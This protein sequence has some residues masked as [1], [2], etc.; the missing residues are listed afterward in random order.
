MSKCSFCA[1]S[2][3]FLGHV[4][5]SAGVNVDPKKVAVIAKW[6]LPKSPTEVRSSL[7]MGSYFK[8]FIQGYSKLVHPLVQLTRPRLP[9]VWSRLVQSAFDNLKHCLCD[10]PVLVLPDAH[11]EVVCDASGFGCGAVLLQNQKPIA[12]HSYKLS[13]AERR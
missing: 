2:V 5:S 10:A 1:S 6:P 8:C 11:Y 9:F 13:D 12:F 3:E 7:G 4:V